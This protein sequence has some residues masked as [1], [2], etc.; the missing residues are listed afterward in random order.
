[1]IDGSGA[2]PST[3]FGDLTGALR[4]R[5]MSSLSPKVYM[6]TIRP[7]TRRTPKLAV[8]LAMDAESLAVVLYH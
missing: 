6:I 4:L 5:S 3:A 1:M 7:L 8:S 2:K